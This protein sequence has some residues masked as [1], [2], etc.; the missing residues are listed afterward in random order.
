[1]PKYL[2]K[3]LKCDNSYSENQ[4]LMTCPN[5]NGQLEICLNYDI[6]HEK[7]SNSSDFLSLSASAPNSMW[8]YYDFLPI[9]EKENIISLGE[10]LTPLL[11]SHNLGR[12][13][14]LRNVF[15]KV[16]TGNPTGSFKDR[17]VSMGMSKAIEM[18][19]NGVITISSGNVG[20]ATSAYAAAANIPAIVF[21][22]EMS[23]INKLTQIMTY[24]AT[25]LRVQSNSTK[26]ILDA[27]KDH[28]REYQF[29]NLMTAS[30]VN[31]YINLGAK[32][33][34]YEII[35]SF[36]SLYDGKTP[37]VIICP[38]GG[39]G[40]LAS[41]YQGMVDLIELEIIEDIP[42]IIGVQPS[43]CAPLA[44]AILRNITNK[45][46]ES[47]F[48]DPWE[49]INTIAS[50]LADDVPMDAR[51]A[52][53]AIKKSRGT[54][55]IVTDDEIIDAEKYLAMTEGIFAEPSSATTIAALKH[56][57]EDAIIDSDDY[58]VSLITGS[59]FKDLNA[60]KRFNPQ[61]R[62]VPLNHNWDV[63]FKEM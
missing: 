61:P 8:K 62:S 46:I 5:C 30:P 60:C 43:G 41:I 32:T 54:A 11:R 49:N 13:L 25:L 33:I 7:I 17:Q 21:V 23:P 20:A 16:E 24:G 48:E 34:A 4:Q 31:P 22:H 37:D 47:L 52:V 1:M 12:D 19:T 3:C 57:K 9:L 10:G 28:C 26:N 51:L 63:E 42:K 58:I 45:D 56:L 36:I 35:N 50:A 38:V 44:T 6:L 2:L 59:G 55:Y 14:G 40:L 27:V 39:G 18:K 29:T 15:L 53:P